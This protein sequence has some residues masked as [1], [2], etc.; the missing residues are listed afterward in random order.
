MVLPKKP[1][2][3]TNRANFEHRISIALTC[4]GQT[5]RIFRKHNLVPRELNETFLE[6]W[7]MESLFGYFYAYHKQFDILEIC[8]KCKS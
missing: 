1:T 3:L 4:L 6:I 2:T 7:L 8:E 5:G